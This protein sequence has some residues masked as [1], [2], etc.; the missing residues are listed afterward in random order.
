M[1][2]IDP[3]GCRK[4]RGGG[5]CAFLPAKDLA[6]RAR[7]DVSHE[8]SRGCFVKDSVLCR[9]GFVLYTAVISFG[10]CA[11]L[12]DGRC[13]LTMGVRGFFVLVLAAAAALDDVATG[14]IS[15]L[16]SGAGLCAAIYLAAFTSD[17]SLPGALIGGAVPALSGWLLFR[18][19]LVGAGDIKLLTVIGLMTGDRVILTFLLASFL[20]GAILSAALLASCSSIRERAGVMKAFLLRLSDGGA[21]SYRE[22][23]REM[24]GRGAELHFAVPVLMAALL[25]AG[26]LLP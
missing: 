25:Y 20:C 15:N 3:T 23:S 4:R 18:F 11:A 24:S 8:K 26:G 14:R 9:F 10:A 5:P 21:I 17:L 12:A 19:R 6:G 22:L 1:K 13:V 2:A 7:I 16:I